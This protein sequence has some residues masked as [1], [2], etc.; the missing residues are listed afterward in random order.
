VGSITVAE[1]E[2][3]AAIAARMCQ[4]VRCIEL[5]LGTPHAALAPRDAL[6]SVSGAAAVGA[7]T[8]AVRSSVGTLPLVVKLTAT[9]GDL[10]E[11]A[12]AALASGADAVAMTGRFQGFLP[13]PET[14]EP[15]LRTAAA[16]GGGWALPMSL[17]WIS[18]CR[19][20]LGGDAP[21]VGTNGARSGLDVV[22]FLL[23]GASAVEMASAVLTRGPAALSDALAE[24]EAYAARRGLQHLAELV[25][26]AADRALTYGELQPGRPRRPWERYYANMGGVD[27]KRD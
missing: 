12:R 20:A 21:L 11:Q 4:A 8:K 27:A 26:V 2:P 9:G 14:W 10:V 15:V 16:I 5:N 18:A 7:Y 22:R 17:Y 3:A 24:I 13:D 6:A 25:G 19:K 23:S 1:V